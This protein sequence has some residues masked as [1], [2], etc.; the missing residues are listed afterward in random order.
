MNLDT[1]KAAWQ[2]VRALRASVSDSAT[3]LYL[4]AARGAF[5]QEI[6]PRRTYWAVLSQNMDRASRGEITSK[7]DRL[8]YVRRARAMRRDGFRNNWAGC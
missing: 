3:G 7:G 2:R 4:S 8:F 6:E 1:F 5:R